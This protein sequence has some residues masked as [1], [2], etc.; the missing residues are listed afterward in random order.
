M[1]N[2]MY[3]YIHIYDYIY[4]IKYVCMYEWLATTWEMMLPACDK[5][6]EYVK[7]SF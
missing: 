2:F 1:K 4:E 5:G 6:T 3:L 7:K